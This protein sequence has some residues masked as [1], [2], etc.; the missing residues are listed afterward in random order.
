MESDKDT[1]IPD[2]RRQKHEVSKLVRKDERSFSFGVLNLIFSSWLVGSA[3]HLYWIWYSVKIV[4]LLTRRVVK[5]TAKK[6]QFF[7]IEFCY[8]VNYW[9]VIYYAICLIEANTSFLDS[10]RSW[11]D[12]L[13]VPLFRVAF[14]WCVGPVAMSVPILHNSLIF[15]SSDQI[16][17]LT[18]HLSPNIALYGMRWW[19]KDPPFQRRFIS[20]V[21][22]HLTEVR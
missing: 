5:Y 10:Y 19:M 22:R 14:T 11:L 18:V 16:T 8:L 4:F 9:S 3:P 21:T 6:W 17:I 15:H 1:K 20:G 7:L 12:P 13:G 2:P